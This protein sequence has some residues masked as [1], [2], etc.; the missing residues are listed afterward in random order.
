MSHTPHM[1]TGVPAPSG[2]VPWTVKR[3]IPSAPRPPAPNLPCNRLYHSCWL[4][5]D[6]Q[7]E[8]LSRKGPSIPLFRDAFSAL[9]RGSLLPT[10]EGPVAIE[11]VLPG[12]RVSTSNGLQTLLWKGSSAF[13]PAPIGQ[14]GGIR[15]YRIPADA[16][17]FGR[18]MPDLVLGPAARLVDRAPALRTV[19]P[20][21]AA[22]V[23]VAP[24]ADGMSV[25]EV[26]P[27]ASV[28]LFHIGFA[29]HCLLTVNGV[30]IESHHPGPVD[31][32]RLGPAMT[33]LFL[34]LFPHVASLSGF[35]RMTCP[36]LTVEQYQTLGAA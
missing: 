12:M 17:G 5:P 35:G 3:R 8:D 34:G 6:G 15:L 32:A 33:E 20:D 26:T 18:P 22:L 4:A 14:A 13:A 25:I 1:R 2:N 27:V 7:I 24:F 10:E 30:E 16:F 29:E 11:D 23:P 28:E 31:T 21:G 9:A 36:R 19:T